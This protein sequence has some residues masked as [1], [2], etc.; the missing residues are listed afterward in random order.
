[1]IHFTKKMWLKFSW[2]PQKAIQSITGRFKSVPKELYFSQTSQ[3]HLETAA[4]SLEILMNAH[5]FQDQQKFCQRVGKLI[6]SLIWASYKETRAEIHFTPT[7]SEL[8]IQQTSQHVTWPSIQ[9]ELRPH[10]SMFQANLKSSLSWTWLSPK[11]HLNDSWYPFL[12]ALN[13]SIIF[14]D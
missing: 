14:L 9:Q 12:S 13:L 6:W 1:M 8:T 2:P 4:N 3:I 7:F 10:A 5:K 11:L